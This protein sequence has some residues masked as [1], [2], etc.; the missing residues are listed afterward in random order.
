MH[1][2]TEE[3]DAEI[4]LKAFE[5][6]RELAFRHGQIPGGLLEFG[7]EFQG[8]RIPLVTRPRG[9]FKPMSMRHLLSIKTVFPRRGRK[10]WYDDQNEALIRL[11]DSD[12]AFDYSFMGANPDATPNLLLRD[13]MENR[14]P[15]IYFV[16]ISPGLYQ[17]VFPAFI[18]RWDPHALKCGIGFSQAE[19]DAAPPESPRERRYALRA[20]KQ[21]L[22]QASFRQAVMAAYQSRCALSLLPEV[23]LLD[24]AH[25]IADHD[26]ALGQ[27]SVRNGIP[28]S[29][30]HHA[31]FDAGLIGID[32]DY[33]VHVSEQLL[34]MRDGPILEAMKGLHG[35]RIHLPRRHSDYPDRERLALRFERFRSA[36]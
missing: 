9:I 6:V 2:I 22:H 12:D 17:A 31:A 18:S 8:E 19:E 1:V 26:D 24:A 36:G 11:F 20:V 5:C 30:I 25:I 32:Q 10:T 15:L 23:R 34:E 29:K 28:M 35:N 7:F 16:G 4:R 21:R 13:A 33:K 3:R 27:P 14:I